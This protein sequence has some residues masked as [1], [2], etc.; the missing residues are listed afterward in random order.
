VSFFKSLLLA[1]TATIFLTYFF[2]VSVLE[3]LNIDL[4]F[5]VN[6]A[7]HQQ[8]IEPLKKISVSA[9]IVVSL[10]LVALFIVLSVFGTLMFITVVSVGAIMMLMVGVFWPVFLIAIVIWLITKETTRQQ[11]T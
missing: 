6:E 8:L 9:I 1:V 4:N 2:G 10:L 7:Q 11:L 5:S 3:W